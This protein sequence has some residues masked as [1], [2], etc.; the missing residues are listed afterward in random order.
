[1]HN[2]ER[3]DI[4]HLSTAL[5]VTIC[6]A[7]ARTRIGRH[8]FLVNQ[9]ERSI[10]SVPSNIAEGSG[11]PTDAKFAHFIGIAIGSVA[12]S[13]SHLTQMEKLG[14]LPNEDLPG[15]RAELQRIRRM[16]ESF[17]RRLLNE[18]PI[19]HPVPRPKSRSPVHSPPSRS[20]T[21]VPSPE[22]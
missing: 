2:H 7:L 20:Y 8:R 13:M 1:M 19:D 9:L 4:W 21:R 18:Q 15:W 10:T 3:I 5:S 16:S 11:Q 6:R 17:Q 22:S 14:L 12:E